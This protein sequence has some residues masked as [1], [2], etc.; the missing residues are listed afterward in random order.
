MEI[1]ILII[2]DALSSQVGWAI[3]KH[4]FWWGVSVLIDL[5]GGNYG[6]GALMKTIAVSWLG[7]P[8]PFVLGRER[9]ICLGHPTFD[10][11]DRDFY[12]FF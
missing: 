3:G 8:S 1:G 6:I 4:G 9:V 11:I 7:E 2:G 12:A 5:L 10:V